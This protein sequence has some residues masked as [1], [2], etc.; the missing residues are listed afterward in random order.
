MK[1]SSII[2]SSFILGSLIL[3]SCST[4]K[5]ASSDTSDNLYFMASDARI[6][7]EYAVQNNNPEQFQ[8]LSSSATETIPQES[9]SSRNV[10]PDYIAR[11][12]AEEGTA[13]DDVVYFDEASGEESNPDINAYDNYRVGSSGNNSN[14]S[15]SMAFNMGM[16]YGMNSFGMGGFYNPYM[17]YGFRPGFNMNIGFGFG[18]PFYRSMYYRPSYGMMGFYDPWGPVYG[19]GGYGYGYPGYGYS[20]M[21]SSNP[22]YVLPGGEYGDR[23]VVR[24]ARPTRGSSLAASRGGSISNV[25]LQ[26]STARAQARRDVL[27]STN[28]ATPR[29]LVSNSD[30]SRVSARDFSSS[31]NDYYNSRAREGSSRNVGSAAMDRSVS[32]SRSAMP[33]ARPSVSTSNTR[34]I[35]TG[36]GGTVRSAIPSNSRTS[37][38]SYNRSNVPARSSSPTYNRGET[39]TRTVTPSRTSTPTSTPTYTAPT[40]SSGSTGTSTGTTRTTTTTTTTRGGRGN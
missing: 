17:G 20:P 21:F 4:S 2:T 6:A 18:N 16:M 5:L 31:Q 22:I 40:R 19:M 13:Q 9:F 15:N 10:N 1:N 38:P 29:R 37:S 12:Q 23:Q 26:P 7:T 25:A 34:S 14:F 32:S 39:N 30:N 28:S 8:T 3:V 35:D 27:N 36:R 33:S 11:Y 24:G